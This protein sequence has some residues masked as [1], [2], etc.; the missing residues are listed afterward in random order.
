MLLQ[1]FKRR[2]LN[3]NS[4]WRWAVK[5]NQCTQP[6]AQKPVITGHDPGAYV[7]LAAFRCG[8]ADTIHK[9][10]GR[11]GNMMQKLVHMCGK[12]TTSTPNL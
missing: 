7:W 8:P 9:P 10:L 1:T 3:V 12:N 2:M 6:R 11:P 5:N 4:P